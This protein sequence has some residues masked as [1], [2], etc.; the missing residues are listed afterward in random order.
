MELI[1]Q[2]EASWVEPDSLACFFISPLG[3]R[4]LNA[5][6]V[7]REV[8]FTM[9]V[10]AK[11]IYDKQNIGDLNEKI[12]LQGIVDCYFLEE[13]GYVLLDY[14]TDRVSKDNLAQ[15][16]NMIFRLKHTSRLWKREQG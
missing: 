16:K 1:S 8:P 11:D 2:E 5:L 9:E 13:D 3:R 4:M 7:K 6:E 10:D 14:K 15:A 12:T